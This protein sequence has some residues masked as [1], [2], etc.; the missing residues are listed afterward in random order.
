MTTGRTKKLKKNATDIRILFHTTVAETIKDHDMI[1]RGDRVL[2]AVSG[3]PDSVAMLFSF[4]EI[5][6]RCSIDLGVAHINHMLRGEDA[7]H[8][9]QFVRQLAQKLDL[10]FYSLQA[11]VKRFAEK[12]RL[13]LEEAG[14]KIR[15]DFL[16]AT[17]L[18]KDYTKIATGHTMDDNAELILMNLL[19]GAGIKGLSGI[20]PVRD[21]FIR[22]LIR[23]S[24]TD[25]LDF[26]RHEG[27]EFAVDASNHDPA[28][29]RN[30]IRN[31]LIP[32]LC[33]EYNP[34]L[35]QTLNR[36]GD[37]LKIEG[38]F[39]EEFTDN[40][41]EKCLTTSDRKSVSLDLDELSTL[42]PAILR[43]VIRKA[44]KRIKTD[45]KSISSGHTEDITGFC[46]N[47]ET[48]KSLDLPGRIRVYKY[49]EHILIKKEDKPL[50]TLGKKKGDPGGN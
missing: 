30:R 45:L 19:R 38:H 7:F 20:P 16:L 43:R 11:D 37:I 50:R 6:E 40:A 28:F 49:K 4:L 34:N 22:P 12:K 18:E 21:K 27:I 15:Y 36:T 48:G 23:L 5:K 42:H 8:D 44:V 2:A 29:L 17:A 25:I 24:K 10:A 41:F 1:T 39:L 46:F 9:E 13:S 26:L 14:R 32:F 3:G 35:T 31:Q 47:A 33:A